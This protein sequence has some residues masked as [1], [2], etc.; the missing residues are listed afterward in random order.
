CPT[1]FRSRASEITDLDMKIIEAKRL[2]DVEKANELM[3]EMDNIFKNM[4]P[5]QLAAQSALSDF[6]D[7]YQDLVTKMEPGVLMSF[8]GALDAI[9]RTLEMATP[10]ISASVDAVN[11]L[12][13]A[14]NRNLESEDVQAFFEYLN[15][16]GAAA[17]EVI[18]KSMGNFLVGILNLMTAFAPLSVSMQG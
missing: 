7:T 1:L 6:R 14:L 5:A 11:R 8:S 18:S 12:M 17:L 9:A 15:N 16:Y 13:D 4:S 3:A 10:M 2:G